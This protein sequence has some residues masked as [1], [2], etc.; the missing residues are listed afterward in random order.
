MPRAIGQRG[1]HEERLPRHGPDSH[2]ANILETIILVQGQHQILTALAP[3]GQVVQNG[4]VLSIAD[5]PRQP[6][7]PGA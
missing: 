7:A 2:P 1:E 6:P 5:D 3:S 4:D